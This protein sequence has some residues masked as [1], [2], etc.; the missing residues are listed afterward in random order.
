MMGE[1]TRFD[2][3][4]SHEADGAQTAHQLYAEFKIT[5]PAAAA[6]PLT[7]FDGTVTDVRQQVTGDTCVADVT[8]FDPETAHETEN[9]SRIV[10]SRTTLDSHCLCDVFLEFDCIPQITAVDGRT[11]ILETHLPD[12]SQLTDLVDGLKSVTESVSL[13]RLIRVGEGNGRTSQT[14]TLDLH[15][16]T[17]KQREAATKAVAA[18][19]YRTPRETSVGDLAADL[20]ISKS[21]MSQRL[22][23]VESNCGH[24]VHLNCLK[25]LNC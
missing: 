16:V 11:M 21:A 25:I 17:D 2:S 24:G 15:T 1:S 4:R 8:V 10:R 6:C 3:G 23:A 5:L 20:E 19:Y 22:S 13:R 14:V 7:S 9:R 18:G 12:R